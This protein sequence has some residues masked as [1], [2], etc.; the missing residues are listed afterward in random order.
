MT[1]LDF[2]LDIGT[3]GVTGLL[4]RRDGDALIVEYVASEE[5]RDRAMQDGQIHDIAAV[6]R[7]LLTVKTKLE[8]DA[9][10]TLNEVSV[11]AAGRSLKTV[12]AAASTV[13]QG[14][15]CREEDV[16]ALHLL[17]L[18]KARLH[19][20][21]AFPQLQCV[22]TRVHH[23]ELDGYPIANLVGQPGEEATLHL[24]ATFLPRGVV[25]S[26]DST[27][28]QAGLR[29]S[30]LTLEPIAAQHV[31][32][33]P[34]MHRL[35]VALVDVGA[36]TSDIAITAHGHVLGF[37]MV[38]VAGD[39]MTDAIAE[40]FLL[41]FP[42]AEALKR[43]LVDV[44]AVAVEDIL[45]NPR[46]LVSADVI[47]TLSPFIKSLADSIAGELLKVNGGTAP[48]AVMLIGGGA[49][50]PRLAEELS[51]A[52]G[53]TPE[54]VRVR[55]RTTLA[56]VRGCEDAL[57]GPES[58]TP[59]GIAAL[60]G[61]TSV[62]PLSVQ[63]EERTVRLF[64]FYELT[65]GD[66]LVEA[67]V[68]LADL[69]PRPGPAVVVEVN[70]EIRALRG[71]SGSGGQLLRN[72]QPTTV[73]DVL[74]A[75]DSLQVLRARTGTLGHGTIALLLGPEIR[76]R[77]LVINGQELAVNPN[78]MVNGREAHPDTLLADRD[79]LTVVFPNRLDVLS[80]HLGVATSI[81]QD[82]QVNARHVHVRK[83]PFVI[84]PAVDLES[85]V[86]DGDL[87]RVHP[88]GTGLL[89]SDA[90]AAA[91][92]DLKA[93]SPKTASVTVN[94]QRR[95]LRQ[96]ASGQL[97]CNGQPCSVDDPLPDGAVLECSQVE[98]SPT[99]PLSS[100][101]L[102]MG[103]ELRRQAA[104]GGRLILRKNG[105]SADFTTIIAAGDQVEIGWESPKDDLR[106]EGVP[107]ARSQ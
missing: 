30:G 102:H 101:L 87:L 34:S 17:A 70:G 89:V 26:L 15:A 13:L 46:R 104:A 36:G 35:N 8:R 94:G 106:K 10:L 103:D 88:R 74:Q 4:Y 65:V 50:T 91:G 54:R 79:A 59:I 60:A 86:A 11:A 71:S 44:E 20:Q 12:E 95:P 42:V 22:G 19:I 27:L 18:Q 23:F 92:V 107:D 29:M 38:P 41:D 77:R 51:L 5:H 63:V 82:V 100:L 62:I 98:S 72:G 57:C 49:K 39:E 3:R 85:E 33:P 97:L 28:T 83:L 2:A 69:I 25:D 99:A 14:A 84:D 90:L 21:A 47:H 61:S 9:G 66:A 16:H 40:A 73:N 52:L 58:I 80:D 93:L 78:I 64:S 55:D 43:R 31:L 37:G 67:G 32:I 53:L 56:H 76:P 24:I 1:Q 7:A 81:A 96:R 75:G 45:G 48:A 6:A 68:D 105:E